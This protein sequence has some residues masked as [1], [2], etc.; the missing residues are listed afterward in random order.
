[1][2]PRNTKRPRRL[3][4]YRQ[5][6]RAPR[7]LERTAIV[8][9]ANLP[10]GPL[11]EANAEGFG[12]IEE[13]AR[14]LGY[15]GL[16]SRIRRAL[17]VLLLSGRSSGEDVARLLSMHR[18]TLSRHL[19]AQGLTFQ[20]VLDETRFETACQLLDTTRV[21]L[22]EIAALLGYAESSVFSRAFRRW[23]G[24]SPSSRRAASNENVSREP[25][26]PVND[27]RKPRSGKGSRSKIIRGNI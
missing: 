25:A 5:F 7:P 14:T 23:S 20:Q 27:F 17:R 22:T 19:R 3:D 18:R 1:M 26:R 12:R 8:F 6:F 2:S 4:A 10:G 11:P 16:V 21:P 9:S 24:T 15:A 13:Q